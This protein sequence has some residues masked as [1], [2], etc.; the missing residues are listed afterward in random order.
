MAKKKR[1]SYKSK[2]KLIQPFINKNI[3][4]DLRL[5]QE[6][7]EKKLKISEKRKITELYNVLSKK[8]THIQKSINR[9]K[10]H[11]KKLIDNA[12]S[13]ADIPTNLHRY[14]DEIPIPVSSVSAKIEV[15]NNRIV[16]TSKISKE[17]FFPI[18]EKRLLKNPKKY[19]NDFCNNL[20][21]DKKL[22]YTIQCGK[23]FLRSTYG[24]PALVK[25]EILQL[26]GQY[27]N[28]KKNNFYGNWLLGVKTVR[29]KTDGRKARKKLKEER[30]KYKD[31][32]FAL[33][34][35]EEKLSRKLKN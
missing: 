35:A 27:N 28:K 34:R 6:N 7:F 9:K 2:Y 18:E 10:L 13:I 17:E 32:N 22:H 3:K 21:T 14:F 31:K 26:M 12:F 24:S 20:P 23:S 30:E 1:L 4:K 29:Y 19:I 5:S 33:L 8:K 15:K 25:Q 16:T 11:N